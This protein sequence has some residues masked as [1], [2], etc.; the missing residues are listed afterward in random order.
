[1]KRVLLKEI[2]FKEETFVTFTAL[3]FVQGNSGKKEYF[4]L[5]QKKIKKVVTKV[6]YTSK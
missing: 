1:M 4:Y 2:V 5:Y 3:V 6:R